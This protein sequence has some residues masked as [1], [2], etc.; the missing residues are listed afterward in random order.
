MLARLSRRKAII[1]SMLLEKRS[2]VPTPICPDEFTQYCGCAV[3]DHFQMRHLVTKASSPLLKT[4]EQLPLPRHYQIQPTRCVFSTLKHSN[5]RNSS[6]RSPGMQSYH[7]HR[8]KKRSHFRTYNKD[9][10][11]Q[12]LSKVLL[13]SRVVAI[14]PSETNVNGPGSTPAASENVHL[15]TKPYKKGGVCRR[16]SRSL[17]HSKTVNGNRWEPA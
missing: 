5:S 3:H 11:G 16:K 1:Y 15:T 17:M 13:K 4:L 6:K 2:S 7:T 10:R 14:R 9:L 12:E 8:A